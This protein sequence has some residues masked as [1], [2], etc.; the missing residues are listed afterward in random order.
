MQYKFGKI[1]MIIAALMLPVSLVISNFISW[2]L[3]HKNPSHVVITA[4][5]AYLGPI[6][7]SL[8]ISFGLLL[9]AGLICG[10]IGL[11]KDKDT[12]LA[13][14]GLVLLVVVSVTSIIAGGLQ[15]KIHT[16]EDA[17]TKQSTETFLKQLSK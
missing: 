5:L 12:M 4:R 1:S 2:W 11:K 9:I 3:K 7:L 10:L 17:Y 13:K 6:L 15:Q 16:A 8:V 14:V